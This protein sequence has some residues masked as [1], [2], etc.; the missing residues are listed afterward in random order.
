MDRR[1]FLKTSCH[2]CLLG[3]AGFVLPQLTGC[4]PAYQVFKTPVRNNLIELPLS[5]FEKGNLQMVRPEGW[6]YDIAVQKNDDN[7]YTAL[8]LKCTHQDNQLN[9]EGNGFGCS[10][11]GSRFDKAGNVRK[12]PA[13]VPLKKFAVTAS[14]DHLVINI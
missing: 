11:H 12:G 10:L 13:E 1:S 2:C 7:T 8:L 4:S 14:P 3:A 5:L 6:Y 9:I